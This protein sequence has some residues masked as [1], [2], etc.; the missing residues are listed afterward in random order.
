MS[1]AGLKQASLTLA[2]AERTELEAHLRMQHL[3]QDG[4]WQEEMALRAR[5]M[6]AGDKV[7]RAD[8]L[9][10]LAEQARRAS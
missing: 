7:T 9:Q 3:A 2:S 5:R 8:V 4:A 6:A 1:L 10:A